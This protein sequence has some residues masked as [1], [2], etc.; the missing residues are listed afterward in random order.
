MSPQ[1][2]QRVPAFE[3]RRSL[4]GSCVPLSPILP[5]GA[6]FSSAPENPIVPSLAA[7]PPT[8]AA[9]NQDALPA[10]PAVTCPGVRGRRDLA[11]TAAAPLPASQGPSPSMIGRGPCP[12]ALQVPPSP[13]PA[14]GSGSHPYPR[15]SHLEAVKGLWVHL[16]GPGRPGAGPSPG[17]TSTH[18]ARPLPRRLGSPPP[19]CSPTPRLARHS[20][21]P[22]SSPPLAR[23][24]RPGRAGGAPG[25]CAP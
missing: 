25:A 2:A 12:S 7:S 23:L 18:P 14:A 21:A 9:Q 20:S 16:Q 3:P 6:A 10:T 1:P 24:E 19:D 4:D 22:P 8:P 13:H 15:C 5:S 11:S 17:P